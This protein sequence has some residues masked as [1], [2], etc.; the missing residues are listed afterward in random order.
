MDKV[1]QDNRLHPTVRELAIKLQNIMAQKGIKILYT[2]GFRTKEYQNALYAAGRT[3]PG[4]IVTNCKGGYS[5]HNYGLAV[6]F[7]PIVNGKAAWNRI[8]LFEAVGREALKIGLS[9]GGTWKKFVDRP[10]LEKNFGFTIK[11]LLN[12]KR[13]PGTPKNV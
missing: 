11:D 1:L 6:D 8:D 5:P 12:G 4:R 9:W 13:P 3:K 2:Q 10:H 7:V